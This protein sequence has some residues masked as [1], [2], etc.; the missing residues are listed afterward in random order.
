MRESGRMDNSYTS[1]YRVV[2]LTIT[3]FSAMFADTTPGPPPPQKILLVKNKKGME[4]RVVF[5]DNQLITNGNVLT[6]VESYPAS[7]DGFDQVWDM[8][9]IESECQN[10]PCISSLTDAN[11]TLLKTFLTNGG[12]VFLMGDNPMFPGRNNGIISFVNEIVASGEFAKSGLDG[13]QDTLKVVNWINA[14][15]CAILDE[16]EA[17]DADD[18]DTDFNNIITG[19]TKQ[20]WTEYPGGVRLNEL[21]T[22]HAV[23]VTNGNGEESGERI[24]VGIAFKHEDL[25]T[26]Y[27]KGKVFLWF[28]W[29][30]FRDS[31][32]E[33]IP[34]KK[35]ANDELVQNGY[36]FLNIYN[37]QPAKIIATP[38]GDVV[39]TTYIY[40]TFS[41]D[42]EL[43]TDADSIYYTIDGSN[44]DSNGTH[45]GKTASLT[46]SGDT[47]I[48]KGM[49][50][51]NGLGNVFGE[52]IYIRKFLY[53]IADP[54]GKEFTDSLSVELSLKEDWPGAIIYYT[55]NNL[56]PNIDS[57]WTHVYDPN[58]PILLTGT[59]TIKA[60][61]IAPDAISG[62]TLKEV[63]TRPFSV[64]EAF[65]RDL[66]GDGA[67]DVAELIMN[68]QKKVELPKEIIFDNPYPGST[69]LV[70]STGNNIKWKNNDPATKI[71]ISTLDTPFNY[72]HKTGFT[73]G[74]F[75][76]IND[77][78]FVQDKFYIKDG[79]APVID[80][81]IFS[82]GS[83]VEVNNTIMRNDDTLNIE[84]SEKVNVFLYNQPFNLIRHIG[85]NDKIYYFNLEKM[86]QTN[87]ML[88]FLVD[89]VV[90]VD[91]PLR[92]DSIWIDINANI[93]DEKGNIQGVFKN[94][95]VELIV[96][97]KPFSNKLTV[98]SPF[99]PVQ[100]IPVII[101]EQ[102]KEKDKVIKKGTVIIIDPLIDYSLDEMERMSINAQIYDAVGNSISKCYG[103]KDYTNDLMQ[104]DI[105]E[106]NGRKKIVLIWAAKNNKRR[107]VGDGTYLGVVDVTG[108]DGT[109]MSHRFY[110]SVESK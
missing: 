34:P 76:K 43:W 29:Q 97:Q 20:V 106:L 53:V 81:A 5:A 46:I 78:S 19:S 14:G 57:S 89:S 12:T 63:Y 11:K 42:I 16:N 28:D 94:R 45:A 52:W 54:K 8:R 70:L 37:I 41:L 21:A 66:N 61:A 88:V 51:G 65:Y 36:D 101:I 24:A 64:A 26:P 102:I 4:G 96:K 91:S 107:I 32:Y 49:A 48:V 60:I 9:F 108:P 105:I 50:F 30:T 98:L 72:E 33:G 23:F 59:T 3:L 56:P 75:G 110:I 68:S 2:V 86:T 6:I 90:G 69:V 62:D 13:F 99:D 31:H 7:L 40:G 35:W 67:I 71:I 93:G 58:K 47:V 39:N 79:V 18:F 17:K 85:I 27:D 38:P 103:L 80:N 73:S 55:I 92:N 74:L 95:K 87:N 44:P 1:F 109:P 82:P 84:F 10:D 100:D 15:C 83:I 22:G 25:K 77:S 104:A